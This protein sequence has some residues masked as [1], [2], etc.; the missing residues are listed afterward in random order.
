MIL[1]IEKS[2]NYKFSLYFQKLKFI[3]NFPFT[4]ACDTD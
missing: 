1:R 2:Q 4:K 3:N